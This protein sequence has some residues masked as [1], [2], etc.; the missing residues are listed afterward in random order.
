MKG[1]EDG[2]TKLEDKAAYLALEKKY[3]EEGAT[4]ID[5]VDKNTK[6]PPVSQP[7]VTAT[8]WY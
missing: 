4:I 7:P 5:L 2:Y 6:Q 3:E 8:A 1:I